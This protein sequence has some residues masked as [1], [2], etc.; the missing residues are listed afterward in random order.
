M[1]D[2][3][4]PGMD[5]VVATHAHIAAA[6]IGPEALG[7]AL[8]GATIAHDWERF[9]EALPAVGER[10]A[11]GGAT[12]DPWVTYLF[13]LREPRTLV[14][15]GG[16]KGPPVDEEVELGY[17][18]APAFEGRGIATAAVLDLLDKAADHPAVA[19][20]TAHTLAEPG[21][22]P[23]VLQRAGF[24][25]DAMPG[26]VSGRAVWRWRRAMTRGREHLAPEP[27]T[28]GRHEPVTRWRH[29]QKPWRP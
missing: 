3:D 20:V 7:H 22:S 13:V 23:R 14:G 5:L 8:A 6:L 17:S 27:V 2:P 24:T 15:W 18:V 25:R 21:P 9:P 26:P 10:L 4:P 19:V 11:G 1:G 28:H 12:D 16:F 29:P